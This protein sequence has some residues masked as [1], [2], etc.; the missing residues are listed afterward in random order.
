MW[1]RLEA[2]KS[3]IYSLDEAIESLEGLG[4]SAEN[5]A[6]CLR[7]IRAEYEAKADRIHAKL[8][9]ENAEDEAA[10]TREYWQEVI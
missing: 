8:E 4:K 7:D 10:L 9:R 2:L 5:D 6:R 1:E 3:V